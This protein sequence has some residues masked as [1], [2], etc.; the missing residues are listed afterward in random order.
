MKSNLLKR[1][2]V[3]AVLSIGGTHVSASALTLN[4]TKI[5]EM[6]ISQKGMTRLSVKDEK[7]TH[8]FSSPSSIAEH[9]THHE[10]GHVFL[11]NEGLPETVHLTVVTETG[12]TQ[13]LVLHPN[14]NALSK[15]IILEKAEIK[16]EEEPLTLQQR[17]A[18]VLK[19]F[20]AGG[21]A[22]GFKEQVPCVSSTR[23]LLNMDFH[24]VRSFN[25]KELSVHIFEGKNKSSTS[26]PLN[27]AAFTRGRDLAIAP[28]VKLVKPREYGRIIVVQK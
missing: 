5:L 16:K 28:S 3:C 19:V 8:V 23:R 4:E 2:E 13:D 18:E 11:A 27:S 21:I 22:P 24:V 10:S 1:I 15:P 14:L 9:V 7:I 20:H 26:Q 6:R 12:K 17:A 25:S